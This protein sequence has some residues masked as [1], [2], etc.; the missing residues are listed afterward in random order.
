MSGLFSF[1]FGESDY[2]KARKIAKD[3]YLADKI[4]TEEYLKIL[5]RID[6]EEDCD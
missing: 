3:F 1:I 2:E 5:E 4:T 6:L